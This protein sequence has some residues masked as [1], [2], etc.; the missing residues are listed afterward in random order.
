MKKNIDHAVFTA[1]T[2]ETEPEDGRE[3]HELQFCIQHEMIKG[4]FDVRAQR[5]IR[6]ELVILDRQQLIAESGKDGEES[7]N[8]FT[9]A[10]KESIDL[11]R[12]P[13]NP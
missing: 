7:V 3:K 10:V 1:T 4:R 11:V 13:L 6:L 12:T 5:R 2:P 9:L 8:G